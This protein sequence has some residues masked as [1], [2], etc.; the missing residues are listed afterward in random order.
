MENIKSCGNEDRFEFIKNLQNRSKRLAL[1]VIKMC[2]DLPKK[3]QPM[4]F[5]TKS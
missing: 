2:D 4:S 3:N 5:N 1:D